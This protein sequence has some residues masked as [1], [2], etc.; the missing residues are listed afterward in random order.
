MKNI[1]WVSVLL[2]KNTMKFF[3]YFINISQNISWNISH[4]KIHQ[5]LHHYQQDITN[6]QSHKDKGKGRVLAI[7]L[8]T[9]VRLESRSALQSRKWQ[10]I[11]MS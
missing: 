9:W 3:K 8:L 7:A 10:L 5:I 2:E 4:Q 11:G 6:G 1:K